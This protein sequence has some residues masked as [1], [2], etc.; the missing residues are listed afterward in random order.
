MDAAR[1]VPPALAAAV[2][3]TLPPYETPT[4]RLLGTVDPSA[5]NRCT[6]AGDVVAEAWARRRAE[7]RH[8]EAPPSLSRSA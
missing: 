2:F 6:S 4:G 7:S 3:V 8:T 5:R 1:R